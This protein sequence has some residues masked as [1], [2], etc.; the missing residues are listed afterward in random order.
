MG[1]PLAVPELR[2]SLAVPV[3]AAVA[4]LERGHVCT[5]AT[6]SQLLIRND[7]MD[8]RWLQGLGQIHR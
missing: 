1:S 6:F 7:F 3:E 5:T 2:V 4:S 8:P